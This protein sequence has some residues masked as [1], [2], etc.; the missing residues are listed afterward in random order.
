MAKDNLQKVSF[1]L[2]GVIGR[3]IS[4][5]TMMDNIHFVEESKQKAATHEWLYHCTTANAL[6]SI[7]NNRE[8]W[9]SNLKVVNDQEEV[10]K[11]DLPEYE[12]RFFVGCF[13]YD[14]NI[15]DE[16]WDEYGTDK[17]GILWAV[18]SSFFKREVYLLDGQNKHMEGDL[19]RVHTDMHTAIQYCI[20]IQ[21]NQNRL[22]NPY[23]MF[24]FGL[25]QIIY[26]DE[27]KKT[28]HGDAV[29]HLAGGDVLGCSVSPDIP[30]II[31]ST[32][33]LCQRPGRESYRKDWT[34]EKEVRLKVSVQQLEE[35]IN[36]NK[37]HDKMIHK[38]WFK[39]AAVPLSENALHCI[40]IRFSPNFDDKKAF[41]DELHSN[42]PDS[43]IKVF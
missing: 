13:T 43:K 42:F 33:G 27:L 2:P 39:R 38:F 30:G 32:H 28:I 18:K 12:K 20:E 24:G 19:F 9:L 26:D 4:A 41:L 29:M 21:N 6:L 16:H 36:G 34:T 15:P 37:E 8:I 5:P 31:K 14:P 3:G 17:N 23:Y 11:I 22:L 35:D 10:E 1:T 40:K 25:Y 7:L